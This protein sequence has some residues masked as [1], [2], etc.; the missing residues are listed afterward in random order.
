M[1]KFKQ[2]IRD[3]HKNIRF[4]KRTHLG[5]CD[6]C[7]EIGTLKRLAT[8]EG[9]KRILRARMKDHSDLHRGERV[10]YHERRKASN[11]MPHVSWSI[12]IDNSDKIQVPHR[13]CT[14]NTLY[15]CS[16]TVVIILY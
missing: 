13:V 9:E 15:T 3:N 16:S 11:R 6:L 10:A 1:D 12:I 4:P 5:I 14:H 8:S 2:N 7:L